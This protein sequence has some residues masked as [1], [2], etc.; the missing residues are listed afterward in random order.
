MST[1]IAGGTRYIMRKRRAHRS[2]LLHHSEAGCSSAPK[3]VAAGAGGGDITGARRRLLKGSFGGR[4]IQGR[5][6]L[7]YMDFVLDL[8]EK[9]DEE[10]ADLRRKWRLYP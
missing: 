2:R 1:V 4:S 10:G 8:I 7:R 9:E 3:P 5:R 6:W